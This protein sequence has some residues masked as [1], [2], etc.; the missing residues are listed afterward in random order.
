M[1][2]LTREQGQ[3]LAGHVLTLAPVVIVV[4]FVLAVLALTG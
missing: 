3:F 2:R 4:A 1:A